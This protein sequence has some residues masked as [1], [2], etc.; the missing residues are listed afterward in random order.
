VA[1]RLAQTEN[2]WQPYK[3]AKTKNSFNPQ[4]ELV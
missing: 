4:P 2:N 1:D 3:A